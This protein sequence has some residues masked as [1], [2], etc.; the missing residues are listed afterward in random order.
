MVPV[1]LAWFT[2]LGALIFIRKRWEE[3]PLAGV[4]AH[5]RT[6]RRGLTRGASLSTLP[7]STA[8]DPEYPL[9]SVQNDSRVL[10]PTSR[11]CA[12]KVEIRS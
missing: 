10:I 1:A 11:V 3:N 8:P 7:G 5:A 4:L 6:L 9:S 12:L 2:V